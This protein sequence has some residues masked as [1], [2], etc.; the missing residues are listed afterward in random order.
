M[1]ELLIKAESSVNPTN[2]Q[3]GDIVEVRANGCNYGIDE[4]L[5]KF[6]IV[7]IPEVT[8]AQVDHFRKPW[9]FKLDYEVLN[10]NVALDGYRIRAYSQ[11]ANSVKGHLTLA[12]VQWFLDRWNCVFQS[13]A[14]NEVVFDLGVY[15]LGCSAG[16]FD[17]PPGAVENVIFHEISYDQGSGLHVIEADYSAKSWGSTPVERMVNSITDGVVSHANKVIAYNLYRSTAVQAFKNDVIDK[18]HGKIKDNRTRYYVQPNIVDWVI[19]NHSG[20]Y[21]TDKDTALS[22]INDRASE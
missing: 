20:I 13:A 2:W 5:P 7:K 17:R 11:E 19:A 6:V 1:A 22:Y 10:H 8:M 15:Q 18:L 3:K 16:I 4:G 9:Y 21:T 12:K 14:A